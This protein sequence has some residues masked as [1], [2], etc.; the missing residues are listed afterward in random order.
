MAALLGAALQTCPMLF[1]VVHVVSQ[2]YASRKPS[3]LRVAKI[4]CVGRTG[5][6]AMRTLRSGLPAVVS[7]DSAPH[8][9]PLHVRDFGL[10][11]P[12]VPVADLYPISALTA[13]VASRY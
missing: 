10:F 2:T 5:D 1:V 3:S 11:T 12:F 4:R 8:A 7:S 6:H 13:S 9:A